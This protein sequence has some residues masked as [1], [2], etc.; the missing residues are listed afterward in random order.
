M[1]SD[2]RLVTSLP[3][4]SYPRRARVPQNCE[5][6]FPLFLG[7]FTRKNEQNLSSGRVDQELIKPQ[8]QTPAPPFGYFREVPVCLRHPCS[9]RVRIRRQTVRVAAGLKATLARDNVSPEAKRH[10]EERLEEMA[11]ATNSGPRGDSEEYL[12]ND[13]SEEY[14]NDDTVDDASSDEA[15]AHAREILEAAGYTV[16]GGKEDTDEHQVR[17]LAGYKAALSNPRVSDGAKKHAEQYLK[18]HG[19]I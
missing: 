17:V 19:A 1:S 3:T 4:D 11:A 10:A 13:D 16:S 14:L 15:K 12:P 7:N 2:P 6:Y 5:D 9:P 18:E 8:F